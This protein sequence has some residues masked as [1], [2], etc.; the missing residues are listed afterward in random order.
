MKLRP[1]RIGDAEAMA[2]AHRRSFERP[3]KAADIAALVDTPPGYGVVVER[4]GQTPDVIGFLLARSMA[5]E[6]EI[7]TLCVDPAERRAGI[8]AA[9]LRAAM[10]A[11]A[12]AGARAMFLEVGADNAAALALYHDAGFALAGRRHAYYPRPGAKPADALV[13]RLDL[14][15]GPA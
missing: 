6:A 5:G 8:G 2:A 10:V 15:S 1:A 3:W 9:L 12:S 4:E 7:L 14:N 11:A 13:L